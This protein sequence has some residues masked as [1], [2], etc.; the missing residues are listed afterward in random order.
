[1]KTIL[2]KM[3]FSLLGLICMQANMI[4]AQGNMASDTSGKEFYVSCLR[5]SGVKT[6]TLQLKVVVTKPT[7]ITARYNARSGRFWNSWDN[8]LVQPGVYTEDMPYDDAVNDAAETGLKSLTLTSSEDISVYMIKSENESAYTTVVLPVTVSDME[9]NLTKGDDNL[10]GGS[11]YAVLSDDD[12]TVTLTSTD[13]DYIYIGSDKTKRSI[14]KSSGTGT[15]IKSNDDKVTTFINQPLNI[16]VL[17]ND[18]IVYPNSSLGRDFWVSFGINKAYTYKE[19]A[20]LVKIIAKET[21]TVKLN[22]TNTST[23]V[24]STQITAGQIYTLTLSEAQKQAVYATSANETSDKSLHI[25]SDGDV[26]VYVIN[27]YSGST[28]ATNV[29]P[30]TSLGKDYYHVSYSSNSANNEN[31]DGMVIVA[32]EDNTVLDVNGATVN[33]SKGQVYYKSAADMT[34][35]HIISNNPVA[36]F[37]SHH[38][39]HVPYNATFNKPNMLFQ[40]MMPVDSWGSEF[41]VPVSAQT[42]ARI[43]VL[44]SKDGTVIQQT[45]GSVVANSLTLNAGEYVELLVLTT[46]GCFITSNYPVAVCSY[47]QS[48]RNTQ[49]ANIT[50]A[51]SA[52]WMPSLKQVSDTIQITPFNEKYTANYAMVVVPTKT[53]LDTKVSIA[54]GDFLSLANGTWYDNADAGYSY[55]N[56]PASGAYNYKITNPAG[57]SVIVYG[58]SSTDSYCY[59]AGIP[60]DAEKCSS[61]V[62]LTSSP[63]HGVAVTQPDNTVLYTPQTGWL[64][65]DS[66]RYVVDNCNVEDSASIYIITT[67]KPDNIAESTC[68]TQPVKSAWD[69]ER[70]AVSEAPVYSLATPLVGDVDGDGKIE[71]VTMGAN[72]SSLNTCAENILI[73][74][75]DLKL[76]YT[77]STPLLPSYS[78]SFLLADVDRDGFS[79]IIATLTNQHLICY[80]FVNGQWQEKWQ[81]DNTFN[82]LPNSA[83]FFPSLVI[84]DINHDG[85]PEV[86]AADKI[87]DAET[88]FEVAA[89]PAGGRGYLPI[90]NAETYMPVFADINGDGTL[91]AV[92][93]N[94]VYSINITDRTDP[95]KN[96][97]SILAQMKSSGFP[98]GFTSVADI[99]CDG[100]LDVIVTGE[101]TAANTAMMYVWDGATA[102][103]IGNTVTVTSATNHISRATIGDING[104]KKPDIAFAYTN[105]LRTMS[106]DGTT[107]TTIRDLITNDG[108]GSTSLIMF[109]F[110]QDGEVEL[111]FRDA[112]KLRIYNKNGNVI[113][114]FD[115]GSDTHT[116]YPVVVDLNRDG[117]AEILVS[118]KIDGYS[119]IRILSYGA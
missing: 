54:G 104:D 119:N 70:K 11:E 86:M 95:T 97:V 24:T 64:G 83:G 20:I 116:E 50:G 30:T 4:S 8:T 25:E 101:G 107:F 1:M 110:N 48:C 108:S 92:A 18:K 88:G 41:F 31:M 102:T 111:V 14:M 105:G 90:G 66:L 62:T 91:E 115:C 55:F 5:P 37:V 53:K 93:G 35:Q 61:A 15:V 12:N 22:F 49:S 59:L 80:T 113:N 82:I 58:I 13:R 68:F 34:G 75:D 77:I 106:F 87:F 117:H 43:R 71:V 81:S 17:E 9:H 99:D 51:P 76:K 38:G 112:L 3:I 45:G 89:L 100:D 29:L 56:L 6:V 118:G 47:L 28:D 39:A 40:Q 7:T 23:S 42:E 67:D 19:A 69:I 2:R 52:V 103:Q 78:T 74:D 16:N 73:F 32:T 63:K 94:T 10:P 84:A 21:A 46:S 98:D 27:Y 109:D 36:H 72:V 96:S 114:E 33:L 57:L 26:A 60:F 85:H 79:E 65:M 44:A